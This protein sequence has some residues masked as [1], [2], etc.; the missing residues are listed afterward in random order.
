MGRMTPKNS[1]SDRSYELEPRVEDGMRA[2]AGDRDDAVVRLA[3]G[4]EDGTWDFGKLVEQEHAAVR[5]RP[6]A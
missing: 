6:F 4:L 3:E 5:E 1:E 2:R